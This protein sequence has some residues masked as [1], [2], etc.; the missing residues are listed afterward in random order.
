M[1]LE[2]NLQFFAKD[3]PGG[4]KTEPATQKKLDDARKE[5]QVAKSREIANG[6][7][8]F[9]LFLV[10]KLWLG[11]MGDSFLQTFEAI[12]DRIPSVAKLLGGTTPDR[13]MHILFNHAIMQITIILLPIF[14]VGFIIALLSDLVQVKWKPTSKPL[15]PKLSKLNPI[16]GFKKIFSAN[17]LVELVKS[18]AKILLI[19][20]MAYSFLQ[21]N[22]KNIFLLYDVTL[23]QAI[24]LVGKTVTDLGMRIAAVYMIIALAD[25]A[26]QKWK[27]KEDMKMSKQEVKE[28]YKNQEGDPQIKGKIRQKMREVSQRRMMQALPQADVVITNPTHY[29]VAIQYDAS[30]YAAP[31]VLAKGQDFLAHRIKEIARENK[32]EI[33]ENKPLARMLYANVEVGEAIPPELYQAVAEVLAFVYHLQGK[34]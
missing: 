19:A 9:A 17:A 18:L 3:G 25:F 24:M 33:V 14:I 2:Y 22:Y 8:L 23:M 5:G 7:G 15:K 30:K 6:L 16:S 21:N 29:A 1:T 11:N 10:L 13:E 28:E 31:I 32:V 4:E 26:Y 27:F 12:Y 34:V 20:Y